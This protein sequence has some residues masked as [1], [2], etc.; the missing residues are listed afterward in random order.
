MTTVDCPWCGGPAEVAKNEID[1]PGCKVRV[2]IAPDL[3][4]PERAAAA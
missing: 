3:P 4:A 2:E 1:C